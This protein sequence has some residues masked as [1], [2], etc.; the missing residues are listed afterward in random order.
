MFVPKI[1]TKKIICTSKFAEN[2]M[3]GKEKYEEKI[4]NVIVLNLSVILV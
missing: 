1:F 2:F 4:L 3:V